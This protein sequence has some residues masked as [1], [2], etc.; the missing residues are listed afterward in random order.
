VVSSS[1]MRVG[2]FKSPLRV[3]AGFLL[4]SREAQARRA[5]DKARELLDQKRILRR[6]ER[7]LANRKQELT[8]M[9]RQVAHLRA[10]NE[11]LRQQPPALP[12][13]PPLP[14]HEFGPKLMAVCVNLARRVGLRAC[15][16]CLEIVGDWLGVTI[17]LPD[18]TTVRTWLMRA[19][20]TR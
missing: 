18:W 10:E 4:R 14:Q 13:D 5:G 20:K 15:V 2:L 9:K 12:H 3:V 8:Q 17:R 6:Q 7:E 16:A 19:G 1:F 11:R